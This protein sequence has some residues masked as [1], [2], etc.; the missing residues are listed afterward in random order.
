[1]PIVLALG[2]VV[3]GGLVAANAVKSG[4]TNQQ[5]TTSTNPQAAANPQSYVVTPLPAGTSMQN[6]HNLVV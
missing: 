2:A 4:S 6:I 3:V 1:M 5:K